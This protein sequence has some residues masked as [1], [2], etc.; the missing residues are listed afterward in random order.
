[1]NIMKNITDNFSCLIGFFVSAEIFVPQFF[2]GFSY[3]GFLGA[4]R[5][6]YHHGFSCLQKI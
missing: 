2:G 6:S 5:F 4:E 3:R 1:M